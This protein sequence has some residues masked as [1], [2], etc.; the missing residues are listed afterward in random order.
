V[1][2]PTA[3]DKSLER[4]SSDSVAPSEAQLM[5]QPEEPRPLPSPQ[6]VTTTPPSPARMTAPP[7]PIATAPIAPARPDS[8]HP[9][10]DT[11]VSP[12]AP[13]PQAPQLFN[14]QTTHVAPPA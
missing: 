2:A 7:A 14:N 10:L 11:T 6:N 1:P 13:L 3:P 9:G 8:E 12:V 5:P 4:L